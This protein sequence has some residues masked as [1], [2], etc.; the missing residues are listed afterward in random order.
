MNII[1]QSG[2]G[3]KQTVIN[4]FNTMNVLEYFWLQYHVKSALD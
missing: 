4:N 2:T 1:Q 3:S